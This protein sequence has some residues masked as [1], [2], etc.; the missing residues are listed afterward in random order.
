MRH[1]LIILLFTSILLSSNTNRA[2]YIKKYK[3]EAKVALVIGNNNYQGKLSK[4]KNPVNDARDVRVALEE[5]G[6]EVIYL[7]NAN[8]DKM[9][10]K[11]SKFTHRLKSS[12]I[13][14]FYFAGHGLEVDK[15]NYLVPIGANISDKYKV[16]SRTIAVNEIVDRMRSS[17]TRLNMI[18]LDACRNDPFHRGGGGLASTS[19]AKGT[20]IAYATAPGSVAKDNPNENNGL[21]TKHFLNTL[22]RTNL[23]HVDFFREV[24]KGVY[25]ESNGEQFP[26]VNDGTIGDFYFKIKSETMKNKIAKNEVKLEVEQIEEE[27]SFSFKN[28]R[29]TTFSINI[30]QT[31]SN[32]KVI[33]ANINQE[34]YDGIRLP[35]GSYKIKVVKKGYITKSGNINLRNDLNINISLDKSSSFPKKVINNRNIWHDGDTGLTWQ[36]EID[37]QKQNLK[38]E[39]AKS[40]CANLSLEGYNDWRLPSRKELASIMTKGSYSNPNSNKSKSYIKKPLLDSL[41][42]KYQLFWSSTSKNDEKAY[43]LSFSNGGDTIWPKTSREYTRCVR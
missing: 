19:T 24:K 13:G 10:E 37:N 25:D 9:D 27:S 29:P 35:K 32:A 31:P 14:L 12:G 11:I 3:N 41:N 1:L 43:F 2:L 7:Q 15:Q 22:Q 23:N 5:N 4:L 39:R 20:M 6:F 30:N 26:Y 42:M 33:I 16:K 34:Y 18:V 8:L 21:Y 17:G 40:Y 38:W 36:I 28:E